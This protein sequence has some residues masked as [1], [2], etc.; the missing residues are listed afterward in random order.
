MALGLVGLEAQQPL[1]LLLQLLSHIW[2]IKLVGQA[3]LPSLLLPLL[4]VVMPVLLLSLEVEAGERSQLELRR[5][6]LLALALELLL[7]SLP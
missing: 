2:A 6:P 1:Q 7:Q 5:L 3:G 4:T